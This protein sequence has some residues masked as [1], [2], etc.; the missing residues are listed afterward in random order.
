[1]TS[2]RLRIQKKFF[3]IDPTKWKSDDFDVRYYLLF[4]L[5]DIR[6][7]KTLDVGGGIGLVSSELS[8]SNQR[9]V[10]DLSISALQICMTKTDPKINV[11]CAS[12]TNLP[13]KKDCF[14]LVIHSNTIALA[15]TM[16]EN[17]SSTDKKISNVKKTFSDA[18]YVIK[19]D[20]MLFLTTA[21]NA[22]YGKGNKFSYDELKYELT[23]AFSFVKIMFYNTYSTN[24]KN[25]KLD[26]SNLLPK[27]KSRFLNDDKIIYDLI[28]KESKNNF[29]KNFFCI[30]R[31]EK[32]PEIK[33]MEKTIESLKI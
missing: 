5:R 20:G 25:R 32:L 16:D 19:N 6:N 3:S 26:I 1:M 30:C 29:S 27:V 10:V 7:A 21:N 17:I 11:V 24:R 28:K 8:D 12:M 18:K 22:Y 31:P 13:F 9:T 15:K 2:E 23:S 33:K 14:D 4:Q